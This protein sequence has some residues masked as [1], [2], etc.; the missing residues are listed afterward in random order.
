[1][2]NTPVDQL[3]V[4]R[5]NLKQDLSE[6]TGQLRSLVRFHRAFLVLP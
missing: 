3:K 5:L 6:R 4:G 2:Q 1:M